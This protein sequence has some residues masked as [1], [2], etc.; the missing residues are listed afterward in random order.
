MTRST[1]GVNHEMPAFAATMPS[2]SQEKAPETA[3]CQGSN[4][5]GQAITAG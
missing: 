2:I 3:R 1:I 4:V 5:G